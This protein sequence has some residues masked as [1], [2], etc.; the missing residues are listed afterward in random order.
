MDSFGKDEITMC[1]ALCDQLSDHFLIYAN[2]IYIVQIFLVYFNTDHVPSLGTTLVSFA[3]VKRNG[4]P[5]PSKAEKEFAKP[6]EILKSACPK[7]PSL[8]LRVHLLGTPSAS[9][10]LYPSILKVKVKVFKKESPAW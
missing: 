9:V 5:G 1:R 3:K 10:W 7:L 6:S 4:R 2:C 8:K